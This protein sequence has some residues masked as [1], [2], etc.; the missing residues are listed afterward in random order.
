MA[1]GVRQA[2]EAAWSR[3]KRGEEGYR[4][5]AAS[6]AHP[7]AKIAFQILAERQNRYLTIIETLRTTARTR[8]LSRVKEIRF[9]VFPPVPRVVETILKRVARSRH[10]QLN[11]SD[12][13]D[14][15]AFLWAFG[16]EEKGVTIYMREKN[17]L[18]EKRAGR[19][20]EFLR[21]QKAE[22]YRILDDVLAC[23]HTSKKSSMKIIHSRVT[24]KEKKS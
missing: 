8:D 16:F 6:M 17:R 3:E 23:S 19:L 1:P 20:F 9:P 21:R 15:R 2:L 5:R 11:S 18:D 12:R 10:P 7:A 22:H 4:K 13:T 24:K 14:F